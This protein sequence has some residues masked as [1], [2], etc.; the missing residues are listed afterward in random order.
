VVQLACLQPANANREASLPRNYVMVNIVGTVNALEYCKKAGIQKILYTIS[1]RN[2]QGLW[3]RFEVL[4]EET[5]RSIKWGTEYTMFSISEGAATD[6]VEYYSREDGIRGLVYRLPA[7]YGYGPHLEGYRKG[8]PQKTGFMTFVENAVRGEAIEVW[9][10]AKKAREIIYVKDVASAIRAG[11]INR[12]A[13][14]FYNISSGEAVTLMEEVEEIVR[15]FCPA[16]KRSPIVLRPERPNSIE[17]FRLD[18][19]KAR[20]ELGWSPE[21]PL[22]R[23]LIDYKKEVE[24]GRFKHLLEIRRRRMTSV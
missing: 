7:V 5:P 3:E 4:D 10:D 6:C 16:N 22:R 11:L 2:T 1:N 23:M 9:G 21:Y 15:V 19:S 13:G 24:V 12:E 18:I 17:G 14:G 20:K 8:K